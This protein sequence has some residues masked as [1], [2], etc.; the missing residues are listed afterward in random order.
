MRMNVTPPHFPELFTQSTNLETDTELEEVTVILLPFSQ[1]T[2]EKSIW[3]QS[4]HQAGDYVHQPLWG[5]LR[6][7]TLSFLIY[8][9]T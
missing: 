5:S 1:V 3:I 4:C 9:D 2:S 7:L 8:A 6:Q